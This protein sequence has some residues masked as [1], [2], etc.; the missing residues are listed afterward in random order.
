MVAMP[1]ILV[2]IVCKV[3][4]A[5]SPDQ[6][7]DQTGTQNLEWA[8]TNSMMTCQRNEVPLYDPAGDTTPPNLMRA[9]ECARTGI[10]VAA[11]W[12]EAHRG[13][14]WRVWRVG[15]PSAIVNQNGAIVGYKLPECGHADTVVCLVDSTI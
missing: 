12:D 11:H 9:E 1:A 4:L 14:N 2:L 8:I 13:T 5:G 15:C 10:M 6:N 3:A 7:S